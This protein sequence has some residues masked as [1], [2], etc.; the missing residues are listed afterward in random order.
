MK[1]YIFQGRKASYLV[2]ACAYDGNNIGTTTFTSLDN[3][4]SIP[5]I[6]RGY[7]ID[8]PYPWILNV[9]SVCYRV[10]RYCSS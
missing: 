4:T 7:R 1:I 5:N 3:T 6:Q 8:F 2:T 10:R 9:I